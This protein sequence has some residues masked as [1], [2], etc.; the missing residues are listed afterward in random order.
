MVFHN[1]MRLAPSTHGRTPLQ[2]W[3]IRNHTV[4]IAFALVGT[5]CSSTRDLCAHKR[6]D[7]TLPTCYYYAATH[8][9]NIL[10]SHT[11]TQTDTHIHIRTHTLT[12]IM[13]RRRRCRCKRS[14]CD[15]HSPLPCASSHGSRYA[16]AS[17]RITLPPLHTHTRTHTHKNHTLLC[18]GRRYAQ[19]GGETE[20]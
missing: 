6:R 13:M 12:Q 1:L 2:S 11:H 7:A 5:S 10:R 9:Y 16:R 8:N 18:I 20:C 14:Q 19:I 17:R 4:A 3:A 15:E